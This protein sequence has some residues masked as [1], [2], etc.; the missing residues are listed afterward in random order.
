[1]AAHSPAEWCQQKKDFS[2]VYQKYLQ[3]KIDGTN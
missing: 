2:I 3:L 1:M